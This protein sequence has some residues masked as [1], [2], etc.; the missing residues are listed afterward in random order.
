M[1]MVM[2][3]CWMLG[4]LGSNYLFAAAEDMGIHGYEVHR[5]Y[6]SNSSLTSIFNGSDPALTTSY[7][8]YPQEYRASS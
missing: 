2:N 5:H 1:H 7:I 3:V 8:Q 4:F 6:E